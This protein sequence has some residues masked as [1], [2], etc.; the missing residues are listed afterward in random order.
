[1]LF[2]Q[3][4]S[5]APVCAPARAVLL[6]GKHMGHTPIRGIDEWAQRGAVW[7]YKA[8]ANDWTLEGQRPLPDGTI[9]IQEELIKAGYQTGMIG[10]WGLGAPH[11]AS[12]PTKMGFDYFFGYNCQRQ[13]HT[14]NPLHLYENES[15]YRLKND[16]IPP[17]TG[18]KAGVDSLA[19]ASYEK[20]IQ[21][22]YAPEVSF[23]KL[24]SKT[25][26]MSR[27]IARFTCFQV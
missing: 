13:A 12:I 24:K 25:G 21:A 19:E 6:T 1:M 10:K 11:T 20:Y 18:L 23:E 2:T 3:H 15:K 4:Y 26:V 27:K 22:E 8:A 5:S 9:M 7:N 17:G 14:Y 16:T